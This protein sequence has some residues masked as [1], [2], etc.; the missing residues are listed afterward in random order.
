[1]AKRLI[2]ITAVFAAVLALPMPSLAENGLEGEITVGADLVDLNQDSFKYGEYNGVKSDGA[3]LIGNADISYDKDSLFL[4]LRAKDLG[5]EDRT[6]YLEVGR[7]GKYELF[8]D[9]SELPHLISDNSKTPFDG[10]NSGN[11]TLPAGFVKSSSTS[12]MTNLSSSLKDV[13]LKLQRKAGTAGF[14]IALARNLDL[15]VSYKKEDKEGTKSIGGTTGFS[16]A[17]VL[18]EPVDYRTTEVRA[19]ITYDTENAQAEFMYYLSNFDNRNDSLTWENPFGTSPAS[20]RISLP[21]DNNYQKISFSGG[22]NLPYA[23]RISLA[24]DYGE[25]KQDEKLLPYSTSATFTLPRESADADIKTVHTT[26]NVAS[27]PISNLGLD[28]RYRYYKTKNETPSNL[29]QYVRYDG[30]TQ[31]T[32]ADSGALYNLPYDY[33]QNQLKLDASYY[34]SHGTTIKAGYGHDI[35]GRDYREV[36]KTIEDTYALKLA[37]RPGQFAL[38][39]IDYSYAV[40][41]IDGSYDQSRVYDFLHTSNY[42]STLPVNERYDNHPDLRMFDVAER[43][44]TKLGAKLTLIGGQNTNFGFAYGSTKDDYNKSLL[45]LNESNGNTYSMNFSFSPTESTTFSSFLTREKLDYSQT[46][47]QYVNGG[48]SASDPSYI[49]HADH[50]NLT[51]TAGAGMTFRLLKE[52]LALSTDYSYSESTDSIRF[53]QGTSIPVPL[54]MPKLNTY[55]HRLNVAGKYKINNNLSAGLE[56]EFERYSSKDWATD[57]VA[58]ASTVLP[59]VLTLSGSTPDYEAHKGTV[60]LAYKF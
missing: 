5:F 43:D 26:I 60:Y 46:G 22:V 18:P 48:V 1:M 38:A 59:G 11:L 31:V 23:T 25:M 15:K 12:T 28:L 30:V 33:V 47:R 35:I 27:R 53:A 54:D 52:R 41:G 20:P 16:G 7:Y 44:R 6:L 56:Y 51:D 49:W 32:T 21:P 9:Y 29:F 50:K 3:H 14:S 58:P 36:A 4:N 2:V 34:L 24:A 39:S 37:S 55:I 17:V 19:S 57:G 8:L 45:G 13:D 42:I 40:R 10:V